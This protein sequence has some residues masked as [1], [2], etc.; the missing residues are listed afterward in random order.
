MTVLRNATQEGARKRQPRRILRNREYFPPSGTE[1]NP[2]GAAIQY[3]SRERKENQPH[4]SVLL[5]I[6][7]R[8]GKLYS[9]RCCKLPAGGLCTY[10]YTE[11]STYLV[12]AD[13]AS[14]GEGGIPPL[15][16]FSLSSILDLKV[17][18]GEQHEF[19]LGNF[20]SAI[21]ALMR[22]PER[23]PSEIL[24]AHLHGRTPLRVLAR[25]IFTNQSHTRGFILAPVLIAGYPSRRS[26]SISRSSLLH[27]ANK[28]PPPP[29]RLYPDDRAIVAHPPMYSGRKEKKRRKKKKRNLPRTTLVTP[30]GDARAP[31]NNLE[32]GG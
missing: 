8:G 7:A 24:P 23:R 15:S 11:I 25:A 10:T 22:P 13:A 4:V 3:R 29:S 6:R 32:S 19:A 16:L 5:Y 18:V 30:D 12:V 14:R 17:L 27:D 31:C 21:I 20:A 1:I 26:N 28:A 9:T 2:P